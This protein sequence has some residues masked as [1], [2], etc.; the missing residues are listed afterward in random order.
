MKAFAVVRHSHKPPLTFQASFSNFTTS[1][2]G[3]ENVLEKL[4]FLGLIQFII[5]P[6]IYFSLLQFL[7][8]SG[9]TISTVHLHFPPVASLQ[10][11]TIAA[12]LKNPIVFN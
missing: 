2:N 1:L 4:G 11:S 10:F 5:F 3:L 6:F 9:H 7:A 8:K 12:R